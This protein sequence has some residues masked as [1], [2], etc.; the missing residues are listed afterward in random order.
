MI[1]D[2]CV[3]AS[4]PQPQPEVTKERFTEILKECRYNDSVISALW[5]SRPK[6]EVLSETKLRLV[7]GIMAS[8]IAKAF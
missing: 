1:I 5:E 4:G 7:A 3:D 6:G 2:G 8:K